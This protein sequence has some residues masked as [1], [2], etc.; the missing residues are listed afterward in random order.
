MPTYPKM[1]I[2]DVP[3]YPISGVSTKQHIRVPSAHE[4]GSVG[5]RVGS[6][7]AGEPQLPVS[8]PI[9]K[10]ARLVSDLV[11]MRR[12]GKKARE[13]AN[14]RERKKERE[15]ERRRKRDKERERRQERERE[16]KK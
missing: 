10:G 8:V 7:V 9:K 14:E 15:K 3:R 4:L 6:E 2:L 5:W 11:W 16:R 1:S 13:R 12:E